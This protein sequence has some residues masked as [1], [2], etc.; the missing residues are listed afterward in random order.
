[1]CK[2]TDVIHVEYIFN[3]NTHTLLGSY[4]CEQ[5]ETKR[6]PMDL[7]TDSKFFTY[8]ES[9]ILCYCNSKYIIMMFWY[10]MNVLHFTT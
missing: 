3:H 9:I 8:S 7:E 1:M 4:M 6:D 10:N 2:N 5:A